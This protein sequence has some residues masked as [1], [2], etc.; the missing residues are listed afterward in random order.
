MDTI[1]VAVYDTAHFTFIATGETRDDALAA[2][3]DGWLRHCASHGADVPE[4]L[5]EEVN[6]VTGPVGSVFR[7][8]S[9]L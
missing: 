6:T 5:L 9:A 7:D 2:L 3:Y 8:W 1:T 4:L